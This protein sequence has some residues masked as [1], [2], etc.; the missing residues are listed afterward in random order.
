MPPEH[1][2]GSRPAGEGGAGTRTERLL[3]TL[4]AVEFELWLLALVALALDVWLTYYGLSHGFAEGNPVLV[5]AMEHLGF[6]AVVLAKA[7]AVSLG[8]L[9]RTLYPQ[10]RA[11]IP[12]GLAVPWAGAVVV[13]VAHLAPVL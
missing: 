11:V 9:S 1:A 4:E 10:H 7:T 8:G 13:N 12:L 5:V 6:G 3:S 2:G